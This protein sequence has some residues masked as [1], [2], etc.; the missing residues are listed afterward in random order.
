[1]GGDDTVCAGAGHDQQEGYWLSGLQAAGLSSHKMSAK[2]ALL[3]P[4]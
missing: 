2:T 4:P 3:F 1:M